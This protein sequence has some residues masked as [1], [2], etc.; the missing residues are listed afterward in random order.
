M[1]MVINEENKSR[2]SRFKLKD[3]IGGNLDS[4]GKTAFMGHCCDPHNE[5][6]LHLITYSSIVKAKNPQQTWSVH[7]SY[8][9]VLRFVDVEIKVVE[10]GD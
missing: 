4:E 5:D 10:C 7:D 1:N 8:I 6:A 2:Y 3:L 9:Y